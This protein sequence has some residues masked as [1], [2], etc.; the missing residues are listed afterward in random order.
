[1]KH[2]WKYLVV[3]AV[4]FAILPFSA[5]AQQGEVYSLNVVGFQKLNAEANGMTM[6]SVPFDLGE[7]N[8]L[9]DVIGTQLTGGK[10]GGGADEVI[11][12]DPIQQKY[13]F[14]WLKQT[15]NK[16]YSSEDGQPATNTAITSL[17]G[18]WIRSKRVADQTV[19]VAGDA[20]GQNVVTNTLMPGMNLVSYPFSA[21]IDLNQSALTNGNAGKTGGGADEIILWDPELQKYLFYWLKQTDRKWYA[22]SDGQ[23]AQGVLVGGG[24]GFWYRNKAAVPF[25]WVETR[26]YQFD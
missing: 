1:V 23:L 3:S 14:F 18:M 22:S 19:V 10:T 20:V 5:P 17:L 16:W 7:S 15:D 12:W 6:V 13:L 25:Q 9:D 4:C 24:V 2:T 21:T 11:L 8:T 26:P